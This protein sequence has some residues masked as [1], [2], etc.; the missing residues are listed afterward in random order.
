MRLIFKI[1]KS[2]KKKAFTLMELVTVLAVISILS[3]AFIPKVGNY[4]NEAKKVAVLN[5]AKTVVTAYEG[6]RYR[7][8]SNDSITIENLINQ[9]HLES[10]SIKKINSKFS[11][12]QCK[13]LMD[14]ENYTFNID[15]GTASEPQKISNTSIE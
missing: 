13:K 1:L 12:S 11:V 2:Q 3:A 4:I 7:I 14:T 8:N 15:S 9:G 10:D 5:E 6:A